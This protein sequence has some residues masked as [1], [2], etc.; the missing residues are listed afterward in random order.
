VRFA[1][2]AAVAALV[3]FTRCGGLQSTQVGDTPTPA[4]NQV[5]IWEYKFQPQALTVPIG[6]TVTWVNKDM[7][8]HT[9]THR[10]FGDEPFDTGNMPT[11]V[12]YSHTFR[13]PGTY[14]YLCALHQGMTGTIVVR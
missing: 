10:S 13:T 12:K 8:P 5:V 2:F 14:S 3:T 1:R 7:T 4:V 6:T 11:S 9:A